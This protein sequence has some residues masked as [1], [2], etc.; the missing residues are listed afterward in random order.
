MSACIVH[1]VIVSNMFAI[2]T[3]VH[4][5]CFC[6]VVCSDVFRGRDHGYI[7]AQVAQA[8]SECMDLM[9]SCKYDFIWEIKAVAT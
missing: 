3:T 8:K 4:M 6:L 5:M 7:Y 9:T 1:V 2:K